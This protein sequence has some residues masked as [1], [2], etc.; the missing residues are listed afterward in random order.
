MD[1][2]K[3]FMKKRYRA[4]KIIQKFLNLIF[5]LKLDKIYGG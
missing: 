1:L 5:D 2:G 3:I 4:K